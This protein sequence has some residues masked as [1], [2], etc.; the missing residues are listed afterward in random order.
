MSKRHRIITQRPVP[1]QKENFVN[2]SE[3]LL[4]NKN[5]TFPAVRYFTQKLGSPPNI[6]PVDGLQHQTQTSQLICNANQLTAFCLVRVFT[7]RYSRINQ[8]FFSKL[9]QLLKGHSLSC[10]T[11]T[12]VCARVIPEWQI[13][14]FKRSQSQ[15]LG[16]AETVV[17]VFDIF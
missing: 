9:P 15:L 12:P 4:V 8:R 16:M 3:K 2:T 14:H 5:W 17:V 6:L 11:Q 13:Q 1:S 10:F 7:E